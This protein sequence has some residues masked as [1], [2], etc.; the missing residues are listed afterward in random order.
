M[1]YNS[2]QLSMRII[3]SLI[4]II[5]SITTFSQSSKYVFN[6]QSLVEKIIS[7]YKTIEAFENK[8]AGGRADNYEDSL[9]IANY[10][11]MQLFSD[12]WAAKLSESDFKQIKAKTEIKILF[13][14]DNKIT[15]ISWCIF[16]SY[17]TP[18]CSNLIFYNGKT[19]VVSLNGAGDNDFGENVQTDKIFQV[20]FN[21]K[22]CYIL[23]ASNKCGN[24]CVQ[25][26]AS[27]YFISNENIKKCSDSFFD[28]K[29]YFS[30]IQFDYLINDKIKVEP[31]FKIQGKRLVYPKFNKRNDKIMG[32]VGVDIKCSCFPSSGK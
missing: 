25:E 5:Q 4:L 12:K 19:K 20:K 11:L 6:K 26:M 30:D 13:S 18:M 27:L 8:Y 3:I 14:A 15:V 31:A 16:K 24:L 7:V 10:S 17:Q 23:T 28:G 21:D 32:S 22:T 2:E 9:N 1:F 29:K